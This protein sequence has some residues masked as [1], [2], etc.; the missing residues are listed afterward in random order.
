MH[1]RIVW[2]AMLW[3]YLLGPTL[4]QAQTALGQLAASMQPG[5]WAELTTNGL[6]NDLLYIAPGHL[7]QYAD[8]AVWD[9][10]SRQFLFVGGAH[11]PDPNKRFITYNDATNSWR[12]EADP[13]FFEFSS[14]AQIVW[15]A[16]D[17]NTIDPATG[18]F[19]YRPFY[20]ATVYRYR[21]A[22]KSWS[23][24]PDMP[25][26][27]NCCAGMAYFPEMGGL[28]IVGGGTVRFW[29]RSTNQWSDLATNVIMGPYHNFAEYNPVYKV[30]LLGGGN[31]SSDIYKLDSSGKLTKLKNAPLTLAI[32]Y[33]VVTADPVSGQYLVVGGRDSNTNRWNAVYAYD[34]ATDA[35]QRQSSPFPATA[36]GI[37]ATPVSTY[38]VT[39]F[40][41]YDWGDP[42]VYLYKYSAG[43]IIPPDTTPPAA[44]TNLRVQ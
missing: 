40:L 39:M 27:L 18:D 1:R 4:T 37:V 26:S 3:F 28:V 29:K 15:H 7:L 33:S 11:A 24:L 12:R 44:P 20:H 35:W 34:I 30:V 38:G 13:Y 22:T 25:D 32:P 9:P 19:Y 36:D 43:T 5:T 41:R 17:H 21:I 6:T 42:R 31:D 23:A 14:T 10:N 16:Y 8:S 2:V